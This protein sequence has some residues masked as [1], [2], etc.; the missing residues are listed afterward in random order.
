MQI[1]KFTVNN[2]KIVKDPANPAINPNE[3]VTLQF[4]FSKEWDSMVKVAGFTRGANEFD[5][6][7]LLHGSSCIVP[8][9]ALKGSFFRLY[10][11][12]KAG[13]ERLQ[14]NRVIINIKGGNV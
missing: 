5:P 3:D 11:L 10:V 12:G 14:T 1:L 6:Q 13:E 7:P 2:K 8:K 4:I 9:E